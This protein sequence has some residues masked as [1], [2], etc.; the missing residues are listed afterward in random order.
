MTAAIAAAHARA[1]RRI[2]RAF[3]ERH[4]FSADRA[5]GFEPQRRPEQRYF[6]QL[7]DAGAIV[8]V[9]PGMYR[10]ERDAWDA[11][12]RARRMRI[13][14]MA[15]GFVGLALAVFGFSQL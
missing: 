11:F 12:D 7:R 13:L 1:R 15:G 3:E 8:E 4:A 14:T 10:G 2:R 9:R 5:I 6:D